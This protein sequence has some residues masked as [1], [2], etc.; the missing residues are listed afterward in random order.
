R[1]KVGSER[2]NLRFPKKSQLKDLIIKS[3]TKASL[4]PLSWSRELFGVPD[5]DTELKKLVN[6]H[7][8]DWT[9]LCPVELTVSLTKVKWMV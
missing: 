8:E 7:R 5:C 4:T 1:K 2:R 6:Q 3:N 9:Y